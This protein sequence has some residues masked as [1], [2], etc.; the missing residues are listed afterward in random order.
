MKKELIIFDMDGTLVDSSLT[1]AYAINYV[2]EKLGL[3]PLE[4]NFILE[5]V[6][7]NSINPAKFFYEVE[8][9]EKIHEE[10]FSEYYT[11]NHRRELILYDGI[12]ELLEALHQ[13][14]IRLA[15]ATNAYRAST[16]Q[17]L[18]HLN[19]YTLFDT[20]ACHDDVPQGKP[21]PD[22]LHKILDELDI[23]PKDA[24]FIGDGE[25]DK[26]ASKRAN[27]EYIMV[28]WGFSDYKN[29]IISVKE[30]RERVL[31]TSLVLS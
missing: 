4:P 31:N 13:K 16:I 3:L 14:G 22:M 27:I 18:T 15:V 10:W 21:Y 26:I 28:N 17:S 20:I 2:R 5:K 29:A 23:S 11:Q 9:F 6:N 12:K 24:L 30:L 25:R 8:K 7:D 1:I 19:I